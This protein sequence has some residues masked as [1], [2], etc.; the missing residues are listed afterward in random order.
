MAC[1][2]CLQSPLHARGGGGVEASNLCCRLEMV[3]HCEKK[4]ST[5]PPKAGCNHARKVDKQK[6]IGG[7]LRKV[8]GNC[9]QL[10]KKAKLRKIADDNVHLPFGSCPNSMVIL[11]AASCVAPPPPL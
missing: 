6:A 3:P 8:A 9:K 2:Q 1:S 7:K 11:K 5:S 10:R 4:R